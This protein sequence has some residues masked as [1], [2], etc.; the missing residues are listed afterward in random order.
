MI[1]TVSLSQKNKDVIEEPAN[2]LNFIVQMSFPFAVV[3]VKSK[4]IIALIGLAVEAL[5]IS[6][7][8]WNLCFICSFNS[9]AELLHKT[10][11]FPLRLLFF[12]FEIIAIILNLL[13]LILSL[14]IFRWRDKEATYGWIK[15]Q[16]LICSRFLCCISRSCCFAAHTTNGNLFYVFF[17]VRL[18]HIGW[19][20]QVR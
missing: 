3:V 4:F 10:H 16:V 20:L 18:Q 12:L 17:Y 13:M 8:R 7:Y 19:I 6:L 5:H 1:N 14:L 15:G 11:F 2:F 9:G